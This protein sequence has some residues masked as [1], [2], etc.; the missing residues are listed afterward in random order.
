MVMF[1]SIITLLILVTTDYSGYTQ[2]RISYVQIHVTTM[3]TYSHKEV[4]KE[5]HVLKGGLSDH[6]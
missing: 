1:V 5:N 4:V 6:N 3:Y 2:D